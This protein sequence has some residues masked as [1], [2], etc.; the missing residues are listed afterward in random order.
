MKSTCLVFSMNQWVNRLGMG[1][2]DVLV[3]CWFIVFFGI[4]LPNE[5]ECEKPRTSHSRGSR[6]ACCLL[7]GQNKSECV[8]VR[9]KYRSSPSIL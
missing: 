3:S 8:P 7:D 4:G 5:G 9:T 2:L 1:S 6:Y